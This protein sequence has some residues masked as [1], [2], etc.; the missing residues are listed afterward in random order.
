MTNYFGRLPVFQI[1]SCDSHALS[2]LALTQKNLTVLP[3]LLFPKNVPFFYVYISFF[4]DKR[5]KQKT[6]SASAHLFL[7]DAEGARLLDLLVQGPLPPREVASQHLFHLRFAFV[8]ASTSTSTVRGTSMI[9]SH[10]TDTILANIETRGNEAPQPTSSLA[11]PLRHR[12]D[13]S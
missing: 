2:E 11:S 9:V 7:G 4:E 8:W 1:N 3:R 12:L 10:Q 6:S 13:E 5:E